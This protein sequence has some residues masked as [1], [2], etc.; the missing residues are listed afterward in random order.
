MAVF[1][2]TLPPVE[3]DEELLRAIHEAKVLTEKFQKIT[4][5]LQDIISDI[6]GVTIRF[7]ECSFPY[8][9]PRYDTKREIYYAPLDTSVLSDMFMAFATICLEPDRAKQAGVPVGL[10]KVFARMA[11]SVYVFYYPFDLTSTIVRLIASLSDKLYNTLDKM[12]RYDKYLAIRS[13]D[14]IS[15]N[16]DTILTDTAYYAEKIN[17]AVEKCLPPQEEIQHIFDEACKCN[18]QDLLNALQE[19]VQCTISNLDL[20]RRYKTLTEAFTNMLPAIKA[21][22]RLLQKYGIDITKEQKLLLQ[23]EEKAKQYK[24]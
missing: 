22:I 15:A 7:Q 18:L 20:T 3:L 21:I 23:L 6:A 1:F 14:I 10:F 13:T 12:S 11:V 17:Q 16:M 4:A 24:I 9:L 19:T 5:K 8:C 2:I